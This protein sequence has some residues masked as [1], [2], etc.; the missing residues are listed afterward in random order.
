MGIGKQSFSV[1]RDGKE[2]L[3][4]TSEKEIADSCKI[5]NFNPYVGVLSA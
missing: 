1:K 3:S 4:G 2:I 5:W